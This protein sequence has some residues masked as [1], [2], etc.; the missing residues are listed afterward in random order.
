MLAHVLYHDRRGKEIV[1]RYI[2]EALNLPSMQIKG[3]HAVGT[4]AIDHVG[5]KLGRDR[6]ARTR[7]PVLAGIA[8]IGNDRGD[9]TR[10]GALQRVDQDKQFRS[11]EHTSE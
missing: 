2:E 6:R 9:A 10:R 1:G 7:L 3:E 5:D 4:G 8:E 11:E